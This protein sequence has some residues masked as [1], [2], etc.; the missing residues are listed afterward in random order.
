MTI[1]ELLNILR[2]AGIIGLLVVVLAGGFRKW[3]VWGWTYTDLVEDKRRVEQERDDWRQLA[4]HGTSL[5][6]QTVH[7]F[8]DRS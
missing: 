3:W 5:A 6:E 8:R 7:L 1:S 2:D 4:L